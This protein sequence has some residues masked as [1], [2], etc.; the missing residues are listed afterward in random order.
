MVAVLV[1]VLLS[2]CSGDDKAATALHGK[3]VDPP[4][5]VNGQELV[6]TD[7]KPFSLTA[8][9]DKRLTMVF[10]GYTNCP[11]LCGLVLGNLAS[12]VSRLDDA[13]REQ[14][15]VVFVTTDPARD[16]ASAVRSYL[17]RYDPSFTGCLLY[18]SDAADE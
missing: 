3:Q 11:E 15:D 8:D 16:T 14:V 7:G 4:F 9:T 10:F 17:D 2:A 12:A 5:T 13:D 6:D 1:G 18:T